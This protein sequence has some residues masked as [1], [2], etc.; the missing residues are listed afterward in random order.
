MWL[1]DNPKFRKQGY[2]LNP[3]NIVGAVF[4][5]I[6]GFI[7]YCQFAK[8]M[9]FTSNVI[10]LLSIIILLSICFSLV[11]FLRLK[12]ILS[13][14]NLL[15]DEYQRVKDNR[16]TLEAMVEEKNDE[17]DKLAGDNYVMQAQA[18]ML[19]Y[20]AYSNDRPP[21]DIVMESLNIDYEEVDSNEE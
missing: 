16:D 15:F 21:K 6:L 9:S 17:I 18:K 12:K 4:T 5:V 19:L 13:D 8:D 10:L 1:E 14:Y 2:E 20:F 3:K 11:I 7:T